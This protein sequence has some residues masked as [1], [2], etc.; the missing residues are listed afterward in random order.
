MTGSSV[1]IRK[2]RERLFV[3]QRGRCYWCGIQTVLMSGQSR[4]KQNPPNMATIDHLY[5]RLSPDRGKVRGYVHVLACLKCNNERAAVEEASV[6]RE[7]LWRRSGR[8]YRRHAD[9]TGQTD[10]PG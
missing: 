7:E 8:F 5:S 9:G 1:Q 3:F 10:H 2:Q 6:P 4:H